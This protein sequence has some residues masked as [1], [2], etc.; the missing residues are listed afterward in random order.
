MVWTTAE[1]KALRKKSEVNFLAACRKKM[2]VGEKQTED[3]RFSEYDYIWVKES[4]K[5]GNHI[6][7][8]ADVKEGEHD[9]RYFRPPTLMPNRY[10]RFKFKIIDLKIIQQRELYSERF[11]LAPFGFTF[12]KKTFISSFTT[13]AGEKFSNKQHAVEKWLSERHYWIGGD[14]NMYLIGAV[15]DSSGA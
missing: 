10:S 6:I 15:R 1:V 5:P 3:C 11:D 2:T 14:L 12:V 7:Y 13:P 8:L 9:F 4:Y